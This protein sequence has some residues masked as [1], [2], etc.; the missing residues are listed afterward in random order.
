MNAT[1][2]AQWVL[3][4]WGFDSGDSDRAERIAAYLA[5]HPADDPGY[6]RIVELLALARQRRERKH[7]G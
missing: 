1:D 4:A 6:Q 2:L 5:M 3:A 7:S